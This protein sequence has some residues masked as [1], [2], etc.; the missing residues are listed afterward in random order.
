MLDRM[1]SQNDGI[2]CRKSAA[3]FNHYSMVDEKHTW[4]LAALRDVED[5]Y[6]E[7]R[8]SPTD[9]EQ[10]NE[11][12]APIQVDTSEPNVKNA[13]RRRNTDQRRQRICG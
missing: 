3:P 9:F 4:L 5:I 13:H 6:H 2:H 10:P 1:R 8:I 7:L 11:E 12:L